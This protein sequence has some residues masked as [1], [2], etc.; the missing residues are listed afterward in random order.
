MA[1]PENLSEQEMMQLIDT[2]RLDE[3]Q[4]NSTEKETRKQA[5]CTKWRD[6]RFFRFTACMFHLISKRQRNHEN[7]ADTLLNPKQ[8]TSKYLEHGKKYEPVALVEYE[9][10]KVLPCGFVVSQGIT[11]I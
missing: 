6:E 1:I 11:I 8:V 5:E 9:K 7:F 3:D 4:H 10:F 2:L